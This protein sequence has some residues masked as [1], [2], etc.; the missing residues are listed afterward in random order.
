[1]NLLGFCG[2]QIVSFFS[3]LTHFS[4]SHSV[5]IW[6]FLQIGDLQRSYVAAQKSK[7][8]FPNHVDT[9]HLIKQLRQHFAMLWLFLRPNM[10]LWRD[11]TKGKV[12]CVFTS[13]I[14][15]FTDL[16]K[17]SWSLN[18]SVCLCVCARARARVCVCVCVC[19]NCFWGRISYCVAH[20]GL[21]LVIFLPHPSECR[22]YRCA[23]PFLTDLSISK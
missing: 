9:Q 18:Q 10:F 4:W 7:E 20:T 13:R 1:M 14:N 8:A 15:C 17:V 23:P 16:V 11:Y 5:L 22:D 19:I 3:L 6:Y 2:L 21:E 12:V